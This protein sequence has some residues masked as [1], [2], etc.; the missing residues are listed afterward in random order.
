MSA[1]TSVTPSRTGGTH[2]RSARAVSIHLGKYDL[3]ALQFCSF[4]VTSVVPGAHPY[5]FLLAVCVAP[6]V[7]QRE[8]Q[9]LVDR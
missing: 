2:C 3:A 8:P 6:E 9:N 5:A 1:R 7:S 4:S